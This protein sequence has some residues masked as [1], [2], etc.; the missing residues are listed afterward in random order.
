MKR[1][2][3]KVDDF[4]ISSKKGLAIAEKIG[5]LVVEEGAT[6]FEVI[7]AC[8]KVITNACAN[9]LTVPQEEFFNMLLRFISFHFRRE[10]ARQ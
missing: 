9:L 4:V 2:K 6:N 7:I 8:D 5:E 10:E 3:S 1:E